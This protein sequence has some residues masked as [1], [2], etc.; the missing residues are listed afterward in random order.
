MKIPLKVTLKACR[1]VSSSGTVTG[2]NVM[3]KRNYFK[4]GEQLNPP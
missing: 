1:N 3:A 4:D 2:R